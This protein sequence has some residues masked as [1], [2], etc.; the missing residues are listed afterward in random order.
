MGP[1]GFTAA[2]IAQL[3]SQGKTILPHDFLGAENTGDIVKVVSILDGPWLWGSPCGS[4]SS[5][6]APSG[7]TSGPAAACHFGSW[8]SFPFPT[9]AL[10]TLSAVAVFVHVFAAYPIFGV[11]D[12]D[13]HNKL[14]GIE[15]MVTT[16]GVREVR[17]KTSWK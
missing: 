1:F 8:W 13:E 7:S 9:T 5:P 11:G 6:P 17:A 15:D 10:L 2:G 3:G 14:G 12:L 16:P 4:S